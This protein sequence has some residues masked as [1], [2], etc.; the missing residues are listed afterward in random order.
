MEM[1]LEELK[2]RVNGLTEA[3]V[4]AAHRA[5]PLCSDRYRVV[6]AHVLQVAPDAVTL[7]QRSVAKLGLFMFTYGTKGSTLLAKG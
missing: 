2:F 6:A 5:H 4:E 7:E 3:D 1:T